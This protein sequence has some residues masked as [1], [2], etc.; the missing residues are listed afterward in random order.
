MSSYDERKATFKRYEG[1]RVRIVVYRVDYLRQGDKVSKIPYQTSHYGKIKDGSF[2]E[3]GKRKPF[4]FMTAELYSV[5]Q[6]IGG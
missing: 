5:S 6:Y 4:S 3:R 2:I 1:Q